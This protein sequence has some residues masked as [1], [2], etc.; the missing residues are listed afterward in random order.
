VVGRNKGDIRVS[1]KKVSGHHCQFSLEENRVFIEDLGSTNGTF[2]GGKRLESKIELKNLDVVTLGLSKIKV[3][4]V[5]DVKKFKQVN[6]AD[7]NPD[8][9][10]PEQSLSEE[11]TLTARST[12]LP[13]EDAVYR[14]TG[15]QRINHLI[16]DEL[17]S[18]S[19]W[20]HPQQA[21][22]SG[23]PSVP[24]I[25]VVLNARKAP[26]GVSRI[27]CSQD[28][29]SIGRKDVDIRINDLDLSRKHAA[30]EIVGGRQA[31]VRDLASTNG[32]FVN[33][34]RITYQELRQG[35]LIQIGQC[36][37]EVFI[38]AVEK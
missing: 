17:E 20:D 1:D 34:S 16:S 32:T 2:I 29:T 23:S 11:A 4:I 12:Q 19:K 26:E 3:A 36:V 25:Q 18:F 31:F 24:R 38:Q 21:S 37:F 5:E 35:D 30:I 22:K 28:K 13:R 14:D 8:E 7:F 33:G 10:A 9:T 6:L 27:T 15:I